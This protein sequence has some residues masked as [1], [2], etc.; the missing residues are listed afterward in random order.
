MTLQELSEQYRVYKRKSC[1]SFPVEY[2]PKTKYDARTT[3]GLQA[4]ITARI[5]ICNGSYAWRCNSVGILRDGKWTTSGATKGISDISSVI[6]TNSGKIIPAFWEIKF[7][8]DTQSS[9]QAK[10][11]DRVEKA[12]GRYYIVQTWEQFDKLFNELISE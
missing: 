10:W 7:N 5:N 9:I 1:P 6:R 3:N 11:Q 12:G 8:G 2:I 4:A